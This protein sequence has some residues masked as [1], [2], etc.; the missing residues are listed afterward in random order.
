MAENYYALVNKNDLFSFSGLV[1]LKSKNRFPIP[2]GDRT[3]ISRRLKCDF[4]GRL[5]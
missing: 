4:Q 2:V 5:A 1:S 3:L